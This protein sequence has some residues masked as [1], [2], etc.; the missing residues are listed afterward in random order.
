M[1]P[2]TQ[3]AANTCFAEP[4]LGFVWLAALLAW[5]CRAAGSA[6]SALAA[7]LLCIVATTIKIDALLLAP[8]PIV[9][10]ILA[11]RHR[12]QDGMMILSAA[13]VG[14]GAV[15]ARWLTDYSGY[16]FG[17]LSALAPTLSPRVLAEVLA[18]LLVLALSI[19]LAARRAWDRQRLATVVRWSAALVFIGLVIYGW[20]IRPS[21]TEPDHYYFW[22]MQSEIT[23]YREQTLPRIGWDLGP[24]VLACGIAGIAAM[25][26]RSASPPLWAF[27]A[28]GL[29]AGILLCRDMNN[30]LA[31]PYTMR[32]L[33]PF[34]LPLLFT[35]VA[36]IAQA[37][38]R[39]RSGFAPWVATAVLI[40]CLVPSLLVD[41]R[42]NAR[43]VMGGVV[44]QADRFDKRLGRSIHGRVS[45]DIDAAR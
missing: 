28:V 19:R 22:P 3:W 1:D 20:A 12:A 8:L 35:G 6:R 33:L 11:W 10:G 27:L 41:E 32:R 44:E 29:A 30:C 7:A 24:W 31:Q 39:W 15:A 5:E 26:L 21:T 36:A 13:V 45:A 38:A 40:S 23:S 43:A 2:L 4:A 25:M 9:I 37:I 42:I 18:A 16:L 34:V 17:N 14:L